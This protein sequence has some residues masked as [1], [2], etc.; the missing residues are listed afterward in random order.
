LFS[1]VDRSVWLWLQEV[2]PEHEVLVKVPVVRFL[3]GNSNDLKMLIRI[4]DIYCSFTVCSSKGKVIGCIDV[5]GPQ[6]LKASRYELKKKLFEDCDLPYALLGANKLPTREALR[7]VFLKEIE[8]LIPSLS[9]FEASRSSDVSEFPMTEA[10]VTHPPVGIESVQA[11]GFDSVANVRN[12]LHIKLDGNRKIR[13]MAVDSLKNNV[14]V[15]DDKTPGG[16][17]PRWD[18]SFIMVDGS[19]PAPH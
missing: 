7:A 11:D 6:G 17:A 14:G 1:E 4:K 18:D 10:P 12:N 8:P 15:V 5:P 19:S 16:V 9:R 2:F 3:S 13:Q